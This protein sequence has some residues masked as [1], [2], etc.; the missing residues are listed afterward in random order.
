MPASSDRPE[1]AAAPL[2]PGSLPSADPRRLRAVTFAL[3]WCGIAV[4]SSLY[5]ALPLTSVFAAEFGVSAGAAAWASSGFSF[6][7]A[8]GFLLLAPLSERYGTRKTMLA[9]LAALGLVTPL[10]GLMTDLAGVVAM[11]AVQG[12]AAASF[13]P[14]ALTYVAEINPAEKRISVIGFVSTGFLLAGIVGQ[15]A[16]GGIARAFGWPYAF[17]L[18]GA[19]YVASALLLGRLAPTAP[20]R[21]GRATGLGVYRKIARLRRNRP[22][23]LCYSIALTLFLAFMGMY[24]A[25]GETLSKPPYLLDD[26]RILLVRA[27]GIAGMTLAPFAGRLASRYGLPRLLQ[28]GLLVAAAGLTAIGLV[29]GLA[30][31]TL[32]SIA[33]VAGVSVLIPA[34]VSLA[35]QLAGPARGPAMT[36]YSFV[37]F[38][39]AALGPLVS[40]RL[41]TLGGRLAAFATLA[42]LLLVSCAS[43]SALEERS[44]TT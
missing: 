5:A 44:E 23:L 43:A 10:I 29:P 39:G 11:R 25:L 28:A 8:A 35:G 36:A 14:N 31:I 19:A 18:L 32:A 42:A 24:A 27:A 20:R 30:A 1:D 34:L 15:V 37:L 2:A 17:Y 41:E 21:T 4:V 9:G 22:L 16:A 33:C 40:L 7:Y 6:A 12:L 38:V 3:V 26:G 13:V